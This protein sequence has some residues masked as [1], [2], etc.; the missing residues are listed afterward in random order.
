MSFR[1]TRLRPLEPVT[2]FFL[3]SSEVTSDH[4]NSEVSNIID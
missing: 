1:Q 3:W 4:E 2:K